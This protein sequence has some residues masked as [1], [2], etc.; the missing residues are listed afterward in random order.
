MAKYGIGQPVTRFEDPRLLRGQGH[1]INDVNLPGQAYAVML[2]SPHAH[3]RIVAI[4]AAAAQ[5]APGVLAVFTEADLAA[6]RLGTMRV[7]LPRK[8]PDGSP[9]FYSPHPGLAR[10]HVR[11]VGD[12]VAMVVADTANAARD[13]AE[14][15]NIE[16]EPLHAVTDTAQVLSPGAPAVWPECTDNLSHIFEA[17]NRAATEAEIASAAHV[18]RRRFVM[19]RVYDH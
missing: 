11:Y 5:A 17:G 9:L 10:G 14:Q 7:N 19:R 15:V 16:Y 12:P 6:D 1:F 13:A 18:V 3:A 8:R 2:R 4:D